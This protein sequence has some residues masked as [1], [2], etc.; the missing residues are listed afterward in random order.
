MATHSILAS[1]SANTSLRHDVS[2]KLGA[3]KPLMLQV[4]EANKGIKLVALVAS[5]R[6]ITKT[7]GV[8]TPFIDAML[9]LS[10]LVAHRRGLY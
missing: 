1:L 7:V 2:H 9:R 8:V 5:V 3:M 4:V 10:R 6:E